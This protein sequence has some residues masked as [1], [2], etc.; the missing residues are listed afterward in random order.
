[1]VGQVF[2]AYMISFHENELPLEGTSHN[3]ALYISTQ[4]QNK[5]V[6]KALVGSGSGLNI[7]PLSTLIRLDM[8]SSKVQT[9]KMSVRA[10]DG[11]QRGTGGEVTLD[12]LIGPA[13]FSIVF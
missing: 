8:D 11:S 3:K 10:F 4:C 9:W 5:V 1:M 2:E 13:T 6:T 7:C 12:M